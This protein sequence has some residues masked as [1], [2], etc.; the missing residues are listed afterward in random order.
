MNTAN[1]Q[2]SYD[3]RM[4]LWQKQKVLGVLGLIPISLA[5][6]NWLSKTSPRR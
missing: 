2:N 6:G 4:T 5:L 1:L 3:F